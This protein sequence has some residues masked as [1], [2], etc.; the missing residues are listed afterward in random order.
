[1]NFFC[2][3]LIWTVC[4]C[5]LVFRARPINNRGSIT[6][7]SFLVVVGVSFASLPHASWKPEYSNMPPGVRVWYAQAQTMP[8]SRPRKEKGYIGCCNHGDVVKAQFDVRKTASGY[9]EG[10]YYKTSEV[11]EYKRIP[12]DIRTN[13]R[14]ARSSPASLS[15]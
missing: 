5:L 2:K 10:W 4:A 14:R 11:A 1:M 9:I 12:S 7:H 3:L 8:E 13:E 6:F 15:A